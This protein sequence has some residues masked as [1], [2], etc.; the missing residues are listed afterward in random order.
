MRTIEDIEA[1]LRCQKAWI[2]DQLVR[3]EESGTSWDIPKEVF[4]Q[5]DRLTHELEQAKE[6]QRRRNQDEEERGSEDIGNQLKNLYRLMHSLQEEGHQLE[7]SEVAKDAKELRVKLKEAL[8]KENQRR[9]NQAIGQNGNTGE[10]YE[11]IGE[12]KELLEKNLEYAMLA[13]CERHK[14]IGDKYCPQCKEEQTKRPDYYDLSDCDR[15]ED[16]ITKNKPPYF[17]VNALKYLIRAGHKEGEPT[18]KDLIKAKE[19][20]EIEIEAMKKES[21][22]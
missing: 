8:E 11:M 12:V 20:L 19:S 1:S 9:R 10:H 14:Y 3:M 6:N 21:E 4:M 22:E 7:A 15:L 17:V 5:L 16:W 18:L 2:N 13:K